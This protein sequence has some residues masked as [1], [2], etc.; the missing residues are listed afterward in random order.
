MLL[1][2]SYTNLK[3][4]N[5]EKY[6]TMMTIKFVDL[7]IETIMDIKCEDFE[8]SFP[9]IQTKVINDSIKINQI[10]NTLK[11]LKIAGSEYYQ[12]VDTRMKLKI[13]YNNDSIET[14][15]M[16][17]FIVNWNNQLLL[18]TN[19]LKYLLTRTE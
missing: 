2:S 3:T 17:K 8:K 1:F 5:H 4:H 15:C 10:L 18:N 14:I 13:K 16:D 9:H 7:N 6:A 12:H 19:S 11:H